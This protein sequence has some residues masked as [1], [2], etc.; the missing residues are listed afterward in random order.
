MSVQITSTNYNGQ[1]CNVT[2]YTATGNTI[3]FTSATTISLGTQTIPF[4]YSSSTV[5]NEHGVFRCFF[6]SFNKT[7]DVSQRT[8][9]DGD[10]NTYRTIRIGTQV[11]MSENLKT[12]KF[13]DG[14]PL[15][16]TSQVSST[17]WS[18]ATVD[19]G[20]KYWSIVNNNS[21]NTATYGLLYNQ[22]AVTG[23]TSGATNSTTLCPSGWS[24]PTD[25][26]FSTLNTFL[27]GNA[28]SAGTQM[29]STTLWSTNNGTNTS[30]F[31][32]LPAGGRNSLG[33]FGGFGT[34]GYW[35]AVS[36]GVYWYLVSYSSSFSRNTGDARTG[37]SVRC[38]R[39]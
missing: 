10:G 21:G 27:G 30:G 37:C 5:S 17:V 29:R 28:L 4:T 20:R 11:W 36:T 19:G 31:N 38:L 26:Q 39:N 24:V 9:P 22:H 35:W 34:D 12:T 7:C 18:A 23:S 8:P 25:A 16:N 6:S 15:D 32:G 14:T 13:R 33:N 2:L 3:P 1:S